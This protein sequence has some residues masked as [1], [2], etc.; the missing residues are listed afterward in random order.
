MLKAELKLALKNAI[1]DSNAKT[2]VIKQLEADVTK[3]S[4]YKV[5]LEKYTACSDALIEALAANHQKESELVALRTS[6]HGYDV[7]VEKL[8]GGITVPEEEKMEVYTLDEV[9]D[10]ILG[11]KGTEKRD[12]YETE[13]AAELARPIAPTMCCGPSTKGDTC[14]NCNCE[15]G[16][17]LLE[18]VTEVDARYVTWDKLARAYEHSAAKKWNILEMATYLRS[19][20]YNAEE[21]DGCPYAECVCATLYHFPTPTCLAKMPEQQ[22][23]MWRKKIMG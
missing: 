12:N 1:E 2:A 18:E 15:A 17:R 21:F 23:L 19:L 14:V 20:A 10:D 8:M 3:T 9:K 5:L 6:N 7:P 22:E 4:A 11:V 16:K 13:L